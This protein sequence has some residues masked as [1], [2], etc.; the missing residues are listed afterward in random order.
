MR[1]HVQA[2]GDAPEGTHRD[3]ADRLG[4]LLAMGKFGTDASHFSGDQ[5]EGPVHQPGPAPEADTGE[6]G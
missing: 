2:E 3:L 6:A 1:W 4:K 5:V